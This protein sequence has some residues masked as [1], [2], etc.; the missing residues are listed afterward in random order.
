MKTE[1]Q[2]SLNQSE[3]GNKF[4]TDVNGRSEQSCGGNCG[5]NYCDTNGCIDRKRILTEPKPPEDCL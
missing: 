2:E 1:N 4:K 5:M 3:L